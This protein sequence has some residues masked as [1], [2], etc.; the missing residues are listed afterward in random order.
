MIVPIYYVPVM[1]RPKT[2]DI[3]DAVAAAVAVFREH[4]YEGTSARML[5][6][7]MGIGRQSLYDTFGDKWG[8]YL[9]AVQLY[10]RNE[11]RAHAETLASRDR[12]IDGIRAMLDRVAEEADQ[13]C[14]GVSSTVEFGCSKPELVKI[15][16]A[17]GA[18]LARSV[19]GALALAREQGDLAADADLEAFAAFLIASIATLRLAARSGA[20][21]DQLAALTDLTLRAL[22]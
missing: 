15:H 1:A 5:V 6:E 2:F 4:G 21:R 17:A 20:G 9:A 12:A 19:G 14:L 22:R 10:S 13:G 16:E 3:D 7:A 11:V 18:T 8:I